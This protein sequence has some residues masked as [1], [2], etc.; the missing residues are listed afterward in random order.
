MPLKIEV[1]KLSLE[2]KYTFESR[3]RI[4]LEC[5]L[6]VWEARMPLK[7]GAKRLRLGSK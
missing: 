7:I 4:S 6:S 1:K 3:S 2:S 5:K